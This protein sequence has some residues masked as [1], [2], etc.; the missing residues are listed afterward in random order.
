MLTQGI[1]FSLRVPCRSQPQRG[2]RLYQHINRMDFAIDS[3]HC[4]GEI[5]RHDQ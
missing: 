2:Y 4:S 1:G 3:Y 5:I